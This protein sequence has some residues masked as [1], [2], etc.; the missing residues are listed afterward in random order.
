MPDNNKHTLVDSPFLG[1]DLETTGVDVRT[2]RVVTA[3]LVYERDDDLTAMTF[4]AN[5]GI[6]IPPESTNIHGFTDDMVKDARPGAEVVR[7]LRDLIE[8]GWNEGRTL[9]GHNI[10]YDFGVLNAELERY[11]E[12]PFKVTGPVIDTMVLHR[13]AG[14]KKATLAVVADYYGVVNKSAHSSEEDTIATVKIAQ[15]M[16]DKSAYLRQTDLRDLFRQQQHSHKV[17]AAGLQSYFTR[18]G[19]NEK[20]NDDWPVQCPTEK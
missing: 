12:E 2:A 18:I 4:V 20:V 9:T 7:D 8:Q 13:M 15:I 5:P 17:W 1:F 6:P 3:S 14:N 19:K 11:G 10:S 16:R